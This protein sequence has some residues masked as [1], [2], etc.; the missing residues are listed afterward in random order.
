MHS[1]MAALRTLT[2]P[3]GATSGQRIILD[4]TN[5]TISVYD[6]N[7]V[8]LFTLSPTGIQVYDTAGNRRFWFAIPGGSF[9]NPYSLLAMNTARSDESRAAIVSLYDTGLRNRMVI[10]P[11]ENGKGTLEWTLIPAIFD[12]GFPSMI[13]A[14]AASLVDPG[15]LRP[16]VDL[17]GAAAMDEAHRIRTVV[18]DLWYGTPNGYGEVPTQIS[19]YPRGNI[20]SNSNVNNITL[21]TTAN[22][23]T[24]VIENAADI[25]LVGGRRYEHIFSGGSNLLA[26]GSG[27]TT[28]D[29]WT[30]KL[31]VS[32]NSGGSWADVEGAAYIARAQVA[33]SMRYAI[34][35]VIR[36][37][38]PPADSSTTRFRWQSS[39]ASGAA[40]V[41][42]SL[43][44]GAATPFRM[45]IKDV[46]L[47]V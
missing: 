32:T 45:L 25:S 21:S 30:L 38:D 35:P 24:T 2:L 31:Q 17:T 1:A 15:N 8:L 33:Q 19:S 12:N 47:A 40:T 37:Y 43:I 10:T 7:G 27:F 41:T 14:V 29:F 39:M 23:Y 5:G 9:P 13:Q 36:W 3:Y 20:Y 34:P 22:A 16:L 28:S 46:G 42:S 44:S 6:T 11:G 26:G 4:G 18:Y